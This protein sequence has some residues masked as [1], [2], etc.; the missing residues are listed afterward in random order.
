MGHLIPAGTGFP[1]YRNLKLIPLAEPIAVE[2]LLGDRFGVAEP[3]AA[4]AEAGNGAESE[5]TES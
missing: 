4:P 5:E 1:I 3:D 2:D